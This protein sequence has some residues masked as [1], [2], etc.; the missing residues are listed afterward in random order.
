[1]AIRFRGCCGNS[2]LMGRELGAHVDA[3]RAEGR[4]AAVDC[5]ERGAGERRS[6]GGRKGALSGAFSLRLAASFEL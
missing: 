3:A 6:R 1:M 5:I 2:A 4:I